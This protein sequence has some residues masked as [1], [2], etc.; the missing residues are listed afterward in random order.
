MKVTI[1][2]FNNFTRS[3]LGNTKFL[4][5]EPYPNDCIKF[6]QKLQNKET[7]F[8]KLLKFIGFQKLNPQSFS[9]SGNSPKGPFVAS[10]KSVELSDKYLAENYISK[11]CKIIDGFRDGGS[12][13]KFSKFGD[14][15]DGKREVITVDRTLDT[16]LA[17]VINYTKRKTKN[18]GEQAK[19]KYIYKI[20]HD[21]SGDTIECDRRSMRLAEQ[22]L[23]KEILLGTVF[24]YEAACCRHKA[25]LFK[26]LS[27]ECGLKTRMIRGL[28]FDWGGVGSHVWN[29]VVLSNGKRFLV[30]IQNSKI[31]DVSTSQARKNPKAAAYCT[32][33]LEQ[34]YAR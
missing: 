15:L 25:L 8:Q 33:D 9:L 2:S 6:T 13:A 3:I 16:Y 11:D 14:I 19:M 10:R 22:Y 31:I 30:D 29:E 7:F 12:S 1:G 17:N 32:N 18:M 5:T 4:K 28:L 26:I 21:I 23:K 34:I 27:D 20:I 24:Q